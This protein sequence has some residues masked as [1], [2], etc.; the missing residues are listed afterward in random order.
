MVAG[1]ERPSGGDI[2]IDGQA[3]TGLP[4]NRRNVNTVFQNY[5]LFPH[6]RVAANVGFGLRMKRLPREERTRRVAEALQM[7]QLRISASGAPP[8]SPVA[9]SSA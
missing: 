9:S 5:A 6:M 8:N 7:V 4:P 1:F 2:L 3:V